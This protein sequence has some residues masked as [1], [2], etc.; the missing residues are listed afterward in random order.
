M[1][2]PL[3]IHTHT[4]FVRWAEENAALGMSAPSVWEAAAGFCHLA[5]NASQGRLDVEGSRLGFQRTCAALSVDTQFARY[6]LQ[7]ASSVVLAPQHA[8]IVQELVET[9]AHEPEELSS[10]TTLALGE[11]ADHQRLSPSLRTPRC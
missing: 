10:Q 4:L 11:A 7:T 1:R 5:R 3:N 8:V 6:A 9:V 2:A